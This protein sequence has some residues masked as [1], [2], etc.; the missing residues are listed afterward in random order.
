MPP[1]M[2]IGPYPQ[3]IQFVLS[4]TN[5]LGKTVSGIYFNIT[6]LPVDNRPP[7]VQHDDSKLMLDRCKLK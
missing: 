6:V 4:V 1:I 2:D 7:Q 3:H 5:N